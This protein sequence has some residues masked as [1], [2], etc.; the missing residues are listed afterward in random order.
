MAVV[1]LVWRSSA[2][3][4]LGQA[5]I[6]LVLGLGPVTSAWAMRGL[7]DALG[8]GSAGAGGAG[9]A[10]RRTGYLVALVVTIAVVSVAP[11]VN[12]FLDAGLRRRVTL[13][14]HDELFTGLNRLEGLGRFESPRHLDKVRLAQ[15][16]TQMAPGQLVAAGFGCVQAVVSAL[17]FLLALVTIAPVLAA[18]T[19]VAAVPAVIAQHRLGRRRAD[20]QLTMSPNLR[21]QIFY[22]S[23]LTDLNAI[24]EVRLFGLGEFLRGRMRQETQAVHREEESVDGTVLATQSVLA[25]LTAAITGAGLFW[26]VGGT[27]GRFTAGTVVMFFTAV[28]A[29]QSGLGTV[30]GRVSE[31]TE[32]NALVRHF[33]ELRDAG[34]DLPVRADPIPVPALSRGIEIADLWFRYG[35]DQPWILRGLDLTVPRGATVALVGL[36]GAGKSTLIKLLCRLYDPERG[37]IRWDGVDLRDMEPAAF[38]ARIGTVF[39]DYMAYDLPARENIGM[40]D[41]PALGDPERIRAAAR[42]AGIDATVEAL[43]FGYETLLSR[44]FFDMADKTNPRTGMTLSGGQWQRVALA[45]GMMRSTADLLILDEP[46]S[47]LD[48]E[49]EHD[50]H[51]RL[52]RH[53]GDRTTLLVSHRLGAVREADLIVVLEDGVIAE[54]GTHDSLMAAGGR[55]HDLFTLQSSGYRETAAAG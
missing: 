51:S 15:Q 6:T 49:A 14:M 2:R 42:L 31:I 55:Y 54:Q 35:P 27:S 39:Q 53:R 40:G 33:E 52:R 1:A 24:K 37:A 43:P 50:V 44:R 32:A 22:A 11:H 12:R 29:V 7:L 5:A 19:L 41:L 13:R 34:S 20:A 46:S 28:V 8:D 38:R 3:F 36:N 9:D 4:A 30:A 23:L 16:A 10:G 21:R 18:V 45:R 48:A 17:G 47:G 25:A 26:A